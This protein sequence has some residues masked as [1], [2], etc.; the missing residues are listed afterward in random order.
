MRGL[1]RRLRIAALYSFRYKDD[2]SGSVL[3]R[4]YNAD[5]S[6]SRTE[7]G[8]SNMTPADYS[9]GHYPNSA[10]EASPYPAVPADVHQWEKAM[11]VYA[12]AT[13]S[14]AMGFVPDLSSVEN[15][16]NAVRAIINEYFPEL[17]T[18][19]SDPDT[20]IPEML[21]RMN[22]AGLQNIISTIQSQLNSYAANH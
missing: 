19:K 16:C 5:G 20:V 9:Q 22:A 10:V 7:T 3:R 12:N 6:V 2:R 15:E 14:A 1:R 17:Y 11:A 4:F 21:A 13:M 8:V 18:G